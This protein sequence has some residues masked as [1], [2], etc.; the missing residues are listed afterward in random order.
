MQGDDAEPGYKAVSPSKVEDAE[1]GTKTVS[2]SK[3][4]GKGGFKATSFIYGEHNV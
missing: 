1:P 3:V 4:Q 2:P